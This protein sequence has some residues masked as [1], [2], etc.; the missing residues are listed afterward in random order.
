[1]TNKDFF[2]KNWQDEA[3]VTAKS[4]RA[5]PDD[6]SKLNYKHHPKSRSPWEIVNHIGPHGKEIYQAATTDRV[7]LVNEGLFD[8]NGPTIYQNPEAGAKEV[9]EYSQKITETLK[10]LDDNTWMNKIVPVYWGPNK[11]MEMP[12]MAFCWMMHN[13]VIH[14]RGQL[15]TYYRP[16]GIAQP[17]LWGPTAEEE[18]AMMAKNH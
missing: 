11:I 14:H 9:E 7:D 3:R 5:L 1:M 8:I 4:F 15:S 6:K 13:D 2:I 18:E 12:L 10:M 17:S 16:L